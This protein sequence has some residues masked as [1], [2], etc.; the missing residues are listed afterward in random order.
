MQDLDETEFNT[1]PLTKDDS[2]IDSLE[3]SPAKPTSILESIEKIPDRYSDEEY[4][5]QK[6]V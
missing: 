6:Y 5:P 3:A 4:N 1:N 2:F